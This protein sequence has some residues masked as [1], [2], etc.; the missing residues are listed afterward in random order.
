MRGKVLHMTKLPEPPL[1]YKRFIERFPKLGQAWDLASEAGLTGPLDAK[2]VRLIKV[3]TAIGAMREG[4]VRAGVRKAVAEGIT[5]EEL[6][7]VISLAAGTLGFP[8][9]VAVFTWVES[10]MAVP[11]KT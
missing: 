11:S 10:A 8:A 7:Q 3:A 2:Q 4:A 5:R 6:D 1:G 9:T